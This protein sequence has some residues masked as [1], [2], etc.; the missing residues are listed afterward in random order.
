MRK[1]LE[2][3]KQLFM[4]A[5]GKFSSKRFFGFCGV[6]AFTTA[7]IIIIF[8][9]VFGS[10]PIDPEAADL[11]KWGIGFFIGLLSVS[12]AEKAKEVK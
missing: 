1:I 3:V 5:N 6:T 10:V 12:V 8:K 9:A 4:D 11:V 7:G 2:F